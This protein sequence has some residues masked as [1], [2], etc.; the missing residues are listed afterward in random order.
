MFGGEDPETGLIVGS[1]FQRGFSHAQKIRTW[2]KFRVVLLSRKYLLSPKVRHL[3]GNGDDKCQALVH[4]IVEHNVIACNTLTLEGYNGDVMKI[5]LK[6]IKQTHIV[7]A[8]HMHNQI[9]LF[10][11]A[12]THGNIFAATSSIHLTASNIF[13]G[14]T[15]KQRKIPCKKLRKEKTLR[16]RQ[17]KNQDV[18]LDIL[19][20]KGDD[21]TTLTWTD[22][23]VDSRES[24]TGEDRPELSGTTKEVTKR[25]NTDHILD[26]LIN[27]QYLLP[28]IKLFYI[29]P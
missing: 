15:L 4:L 3:I 21:L 10:S 6:P 27:W 2:E 29:L 23:T 8:S 22:L 24:L 14:I 5:T 9:E 20:R 1:V 26:R 11:Q 28:P 7:T 18:T 13:Q 25:N 12:K 19:Q 16:Q 17:E